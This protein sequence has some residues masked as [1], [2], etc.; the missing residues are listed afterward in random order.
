GEFVV[1]LSFTQESGNEA[2]LE[3]KRILTILLE[4]LPVKQAAA[5]AAKLTGEK[6]NYLYKMALEMQGD[7]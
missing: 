2:E 1:M 6:K 5:M 7:N 3:A 4:D